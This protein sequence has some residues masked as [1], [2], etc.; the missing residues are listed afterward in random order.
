MKKLLIALIALAVV[1]PVAAQEEPPPIVEAA[2]NAV[3]TFLQLT[4]VYRPRR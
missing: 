2:H 4:E 1:A 3:A